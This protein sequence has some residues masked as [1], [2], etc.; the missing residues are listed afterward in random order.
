[1]KL[2]NTYSFFVTY[3]NIDEFDVNAEPIPIAER[4]LLDRWILSELHTLVRNVTQAYETYDVIGATRPIEAFVDDLSNWY[5]RRS[6]RRFWQDDN[7]QDKQAAYQTLHECLVTLAYL[8]AP[9]MP[10]LG[11]ALYQNLVVEQ[12]NGDADSIHLA[13]WPEANTALIDETLNYRM[14]LVKRMVSLGHAARNSAGIKVRQPLSEVSFAVPSDE[15]QAQTLL[16]FTDTV[17]DELNVKSVK[18][19]DPVESAGMVNYAVKPVDTLGRALRKDF[20]AVRKALVDGAADQVSAWGRQLLSGEN[21]EVEANGQTFILTPEQVVVQQTGA[22][23][24]AVAEEYGYLAALNTDLTDELIQEG[25][26]R[27][28]VRRIQTLRKD[29]DFDL[30]DRIALS[31]TTEGALAEVMTVYEDY[32]RAETLA[33]VWNGDGVVNGDF[34]DTVELNGETLQFSIRQVG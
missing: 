15:T 6:R 33:E 11:E 23:G 28:I 12:G 1:L 30:S 25:Y 21:I 31:F 14:Q 20:P 32:I 24:F 10:F 27:E 7:P 19:M 16:D 4:D 29:A 5:L 26:A 9:S 22:E 3:A 34:T 13:T 17:A 2:W 8:L 18:L